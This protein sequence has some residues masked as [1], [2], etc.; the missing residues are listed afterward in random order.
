MPL[1]IPLYSLPIIGLGAPC[2]YSNNATFVIYD[3]HG[4]AVECKLS[5]CLKGLPLLPA[6]PLHQPEAFVV[7]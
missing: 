4:R 1:G 5:N 6:I 7:Q 3:E 2:E